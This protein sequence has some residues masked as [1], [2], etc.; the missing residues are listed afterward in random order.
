MKVLTIYNIEEKS[1]QEIE[2]SEDE[3]APIEN[4]INILRK[5]LELESIFDLVVEEYWDYRNKIDYWCLRYLSGLDGFIP[6][7]EVRASINRTAFN[8]LNL[9]KLYLDKHFHED[10][11]ACYVF[12]ISGSE[13]HKAQ[14]KEHRERI[15]KENKNYRIGCKLRNKAQHGNLPVDLIVYSVSYQPSMQQQI[16]DLKVEIGVDSLRKLGFTVD[17][18]NDDGPV[19]LKDILDGYLYAIMQMHFLNRELTDSVVDDAKSAIKNLV[20]KKANSI[21]YKSYRS[22]ITLDQETSINT[23]LDWF[24]VAEHLKDKHSKLIDYAKIK[25]GNKV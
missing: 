14:V 12:D 18:F 9:S 23:S 6:N 20:S 11:S 13:K 2:L 16:F 15:H 4:S 3:F 25:I 8:F 17:S 10:K 5:C 21:G 22:E 1:W 19:D 24:E 7:Y